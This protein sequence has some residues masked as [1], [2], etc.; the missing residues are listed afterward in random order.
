MDV[1][2]GNTL[3][4]RTT[5]RDEDGALFD[6]SAATITLSY[7]ASSNSVITTITEEVPMAQFSNGVWQGYWTCPNTAIQGQLSWTVTS[8]APYPAAEEGVMKI[9]VN[10]ANPGV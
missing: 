5:F 10:R 1:I 4:W 6:P 8:T 2:R 3:R 9:R 7:K